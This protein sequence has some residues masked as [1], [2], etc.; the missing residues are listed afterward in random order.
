MLPVTHDYL[1]F[2]L[3]LR[4]ASVTEALIRFEEREL[5][6]KMRGVL[7]ID[8]RMGLERKACS[9]YKLLSGAYALSEHKRAAVSNIVSR[10][11]SS[12]LIPQ[13]SCRRKCCRPFRMELRRQM[14]MGT[15]MSKIT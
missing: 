8:E 3:G 11:G 1:S 10:P 14:L 7:E 15:I 9:C 5:I 12:S 4:R 2:A 6:R 13:T